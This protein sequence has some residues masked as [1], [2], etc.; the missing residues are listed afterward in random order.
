MASASFSSLRDAVGIVVAEADFS[1]VGPSVRG[2]LPAAPG[3]QEYPMLDWRRVAEVIG[4]PLPSGP[5]PCAS[6]IG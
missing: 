5:L 2:I 3:V 1:P 4:A 6:P